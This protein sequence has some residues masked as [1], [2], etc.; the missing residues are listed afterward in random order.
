MALGLRFAKTVLQRQNDSISLPKDENIFLLN[1]LET[2]KFPQKFSD[3]MEKTHVT[4][5]KAEVQKKVNLRKHVTSAKAEFQKKVN[6]YKH[7]TSAKAGIQKKGNTSR[8]DDS[9]D[10]K[11]VVLW[12][13]E[14]E[15]KEVQ[16]NYSGNSNHPREHESRVRNFFFLEK[17]SSLSWI[18]HLLDSSFQIENYIFA[19]DSSVFH[20]LTL[21]QSCSSSQVYCDLYEKAQFFSLDINL[22][23]WSKCVQIYGRKPQNASIVRILNLLKE[24]D[25]SSYFV[26]NQQEGVSGYSRQWYRSAL[27]GKSKNSVHSKVS[28]EAQEVDSHQLLQDLILSPY[29]KT[30]NKPELEVSKD[31]V[32]ATHGATTGVPNPKEIFY[33]NT[34]GVSKDKALEF[35]IT[36]WTEALLSESHYSSFNKFLKKMTPLLLPLLKENIKQL[37]I[38]C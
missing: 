33:M 16:I 11:G 2:S 10:L 3:W 22:S 26:L 4:S 9:A 32:K 23:S 6:L 1:S 14:G 25:Q 34:R 5:A 37:K 7:V 24:K 18:E 15:T 17:N 28:I 30:E 35:L 20:H 38:N 29:A 19:E 27:T 13:K 12:L 8:K 36:G 31:Q 21:N